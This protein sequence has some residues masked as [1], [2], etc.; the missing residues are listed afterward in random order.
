M[1]GE[2]EG[3]VVCNWPQVIFS[4]TALSIPLQGLIGEGAY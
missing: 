3:L 2:T 4:L 1:N